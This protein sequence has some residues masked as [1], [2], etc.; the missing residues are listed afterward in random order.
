MVSCA[1]PAG[2]AMKCAA[3]WL[4]KSDSAPRFLFLSNCV[5]AELFPMPWERGPFCDFSSKPVGLPLIAEFELR[6]PS[7]RNA[8]CL[9]AGSK[10]GKSQVRVIC[11]RQLQQRCKPQPPAEAKTN[12][13][14]TQS[15]RGICSPATNSCAPVAMLTSGREQFIR[16]S[17]S[18]LLYPLPWLKEG[19]YESRRSFETLLPMVFHSRCDRQRSGICSIRSVHLG[20]EHVGFECFVDERLGHDFCTWLRSGGRFNQQLCGESVRHHR[21]YGKIH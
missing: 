9:Q 12:C 16:N 15:R 7:F 6:N 19:S 10:F 14:S 21:S 4:R 3:L 8:R 11:W 5:V 18:L 17:L 2:T 1:L 20:I 13:A